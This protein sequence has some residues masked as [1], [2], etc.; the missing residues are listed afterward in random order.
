MRGVRYAYDF[1]RD[2]RGKAWWRRDENLSEAYL[3][4]VSLD[5]ASVRRFIAARGET[6]SENESATAARG[7]PIDAALA[8]AVG[9]ALAGVVAAL[10]ALATRFMFEMVREGGVLH[11]ARGDQNKLKT[12]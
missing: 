9:S 2:E 6:T 7:R 12:S 10:D 3:P 1:T 4:V 8:A 11:G 5:D